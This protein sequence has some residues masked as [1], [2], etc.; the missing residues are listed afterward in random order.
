MKQLLEKIRKELRP[1]KK[2]I[3]VVEKIILQINSLLKEKGIKATCVKGGSTAKGTFI[4]DDYDVDLFVRFNYNDYKD[5]KLSDILEQVLKKKFKIE[6]VH[7][8]RDYFQ[9]KG[10]FLIE[11]VPVLNITDYCKAMNVTDMSPLHVEYVKKKVSEKQRD[12]IRL[13]KQFC[14]ATKVY[15]AESYIKGFSGHILDLLVVQYGSFEELIKNASKW[16][17]KVIIDVEKH[18]KDPMAKLNDSKLHSP[19]VIV[20]PVQP[21]RNAAA[22]LNKEKFELFKQACKKFLEAPSKEFFK[23]KH[24]EKKNIKIVT[25]EELFFLEAEPLKG[26][27]DVVGA[28]L[29]KAYEH[30]KYQLKKNEFTILKSEWEFDKKARFYFLLK[31]EKLSETFIMHGPPL[32]EKEGIKRFKQKHKKTFTKDGKL[33]AEEPRKF[34]LANKL[35]KTVL[36]SDYVEERVKNIKLI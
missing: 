27:K 10:E 18:H 6:R 16:G 32:K 35:V 13:A 34:R 33:F 17:E 12:D 20:D 5:K 25:G 28:K 15:G 23:I 21:D 19:L 2:H 26:K 24:L 1:D 9:I 11:I 14:K 3:Q 4:K 8:S 36:K 30:I 22:A 31:K 7:G 29:L